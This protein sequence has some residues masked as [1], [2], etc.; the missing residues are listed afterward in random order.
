MSEDLLTGAEPEAAATPGTDMVTKVTATPA[1]M[2]SDNV[3][4][5]VLFKQI[6]DTIEKFDYDLSTGVSRKAVA[7]LAY[8]ISQTKTAIDG[9]GSALI[10]DATRLVRNI[11]AQRKTF[12]DRL[13]ELR[14]KARK[15]LDDWE[16]AQA[17]READARA[18]IE[19]I[20]AEAV[21]QL[22]ETAA[23]VRTRYMLL[24]GTE[25]K[26]EALGDFYNIAKSTH[27]T[28]VQALSTGY[29][30]LVREEDDRAELRRLQ[31]AEAARNA[32]AI[33]AAAK[34]KDEEDAAE[35]EAKAEADRKA[36]TDK[37][38]ADASAAAQAAAQQAIDDANAESER[39]R[40]ANAQRDEQQRKDD[41]DRRAR[42]A[43]QA[44]RQEVQVKA[45][46]ALMQASGCSKSG[47]IKIFLAVAAGGV[48][49]M[50]V[51]F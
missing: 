8:K 35:A 27:E 50:K 24:K 33:L 43:D 39:L 10:E 26:A 36:A 25:L 31:E 34:K 41:E 28:A 7:S 6:E 20:K 19:Q 17:K 32:D 18:L 11:N 15:P 14:D 12:R 45:V 46:D 30:R 21:I 51:E 4:A 37:A 22:G 49:G 13:D 3:V 38:A 44:H 16:T 23:S 42:E 9:A 1:L 40:A 2:F 47:A 5:D 29:Q 48:P